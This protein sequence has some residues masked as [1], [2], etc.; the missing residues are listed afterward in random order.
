MSM[1]REEKKDYYKSSEWRDKREEVF[2]YKGKFCYSCE[3][4]KGITVHHSEKNH[5]NEKIDDL[6]PLCNKCHTELHQLVHL[7]IIPD[8][9]NTVK[10]YLMLKKFMNIEE[11]IKKYKKIE[12]PVFKNV[13]VAFRNGHKTIMSENEFEK[14]LH[15]KQIIQEFKAYKEKNN[16]K[17]FLNSI[18]KIKNQF[19]VS[20][21]RNGHIYIYKAEN[22][23]KNKKLKSL[24]YRIVNNYVSALNIKKDFLRIEEIQDFSIENRIIVRTEYGFKGLSGLLFEISDLIENDFIVLKNKNEN[25]KFFKQTPQNQIKIF[26]SL[27]NENS[28]EIEIKDGTSKGNKKKKNKFSKSN[29]SSTAPTPTITVGSL[30]N[31]FTVQSKKSLFDKRFEVAK[32][33]GNTVYTGE[34]PKKGY[35]ITISNSGKVRMYPYSDF[36]KI[37]K[38]KAVFY[39]T[40]EIVARNM[41]NSLAKII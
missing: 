29:N 26:E 41:K 7:G 11:F 22:F 24:K 1:S 25:V 9:N 15:K 20:L 39:C 38:T 16:A 35:F 31:N 4:V 30:G 12:T 32:S 14:I 17:S 21:C 13:A 28:Q 18:S 33:N 8:D 10:N 34:K 3:T 5:G 27:L 6:Y 19:V 2:Y 23:D 40:T 37:E 36:N